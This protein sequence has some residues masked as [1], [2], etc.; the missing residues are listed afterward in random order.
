MAT[1]FYIDLQVKICKLGIKP[2][3]FQSKA[4]ALTRNHSE[5]RPTFYAFLST[6]SNKQKTNIFYHKA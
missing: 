4:N 2:K 1:N 6:S 3:T 5:N